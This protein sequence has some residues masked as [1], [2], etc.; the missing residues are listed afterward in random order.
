METKFV[1]QIPEEKRQ[2]VKTMS[3]WE[4]TTKMV[5]V[6]TGFSWIK[7]GRVAGFSTMHLRISERPM[8]YFWLRK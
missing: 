8:N 7:I 5:T 6:M 4:D 2:L 1:Y 3:K